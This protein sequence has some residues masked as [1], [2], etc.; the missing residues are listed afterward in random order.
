M[1]DIPMPMSEGRQLPQFSL[2]E[3][4]FPEVNSMEVKNTQYI[5]MKVEMVGKRSRADLENSNDGS[6]VE[7][8][9]RVLSIKA[10]GEK[11]VDAKT[12]EQEHFERT[13]AGIKSGEIT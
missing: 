1:Y 5:V 3:I 10:L 13:V 2:R 4:D 8:D 12:L 11:P 6:K 7:G 9:F